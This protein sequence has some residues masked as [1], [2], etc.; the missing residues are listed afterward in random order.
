[1]Y[2]RFGYPETWQDYDSA[3]EI[4]RKTDFIKKLIPS[5]VKNIADIGCG[6]GVITNELAKTWDTT[7][8]DFSEEALK[9]LTCPA[10][11]ASVTQIPFSDRSYDF[12]LCSEVLEHLDKIDLQ[13]AI[14]EMSRIAKKYLLITVPNDE[15]LEASFTKCSVC[16]TKFHIWHHIQTFNLKRLQCLIG[17]D[18]TAMHADTLGPVQ[19]KWIP[20]LLTMKQKL[21]QWMYPD[22]ITVCP[23]CG[24]Q[25]FSKPVSNVLTKLIN[26]LNLI[27]AGRKRY[28]LLVFMQRKGT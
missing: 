5:D 17:D 19:K 28:W 6:N 18:F 8:L 15:L 3:D 20:I 14:S 16:S 26:G 2:N 13:K 1:M 9:R 22:K 27:F 7:G 21:G 10:V 4:K 12:V 24:N 11:L 25:R 23:R